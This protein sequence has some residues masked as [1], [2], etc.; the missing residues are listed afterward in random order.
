MGKFGYY[1]IETAIFLTQLGFV[2]VGGVF[3]NQNLYKVCIYYF[4]VEISLWTA[5]LV[6]FIGVLPLL[7]YRRITD[8]SITHLLGDCIILL[9]VLV[10]LVTFSIKLGN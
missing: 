10:I 5:S 7:F 1:L 2:I 4:G 8:L 9:N 6:Q 3:F